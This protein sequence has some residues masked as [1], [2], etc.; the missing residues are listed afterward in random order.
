MAG[1]LAVSPV[2]WHCPFRC[3]AGQLG[4]HWQVTM[5]GRDAQDKPSVKVRVVPASKKGW[6]LRAQGELLH[7]LTQGEQQEEGT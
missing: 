3:A 1:V 6:S 5:K 2:S 4:F 7:L